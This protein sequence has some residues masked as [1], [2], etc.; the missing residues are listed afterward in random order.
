MHPTDPTQIPTSTQSPTDIPSTTNASAIQDF[1]IIRDA[2]ALGVEEMVHL[3]SVQEDPIH[4][5]HTPIIEELVIEAPH[6]GHPGMTSVRKRTPRR[7]HVDESRLSGLEGKLPK[8]TIDW[9][10]SKI[11]KE[12]F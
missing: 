9:Q 5:E 2:E 3:Q 1:S 12:Y 7:I 10:C 4:A 8:R 6:P 11:L